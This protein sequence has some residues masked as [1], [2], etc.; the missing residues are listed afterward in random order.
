MA[1]AMTVMV[2]TL[3]SS[4]S[5]AMWRTAFAT[6]TASIMGSGATVP[7]ACSTPRVMR[8]DSSVS[9]LPMSIWLATMP[10]ARPSS[11]SALVSPD[12]ACLLA[13]HQAEGRA[14]AQEHAGHVGVQHAEPLVQRQLVHRHRRRVHAGVVEQQV[15]PAEAAFDGVEQRLHA[16]GLAHVGG[17]GQGL[18]AARFGLGRQRLQGL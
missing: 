1:L 17:H 6:W 12:T 18:L 8:S 13:V 5:D 10:K 7:L 16:G 4:G 3:A 14:R 11:A 15:Q 9:A 2:R